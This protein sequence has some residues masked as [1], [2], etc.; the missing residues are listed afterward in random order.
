VGHTFLDGQPAPGLSKHQD[1]SRRRH[2]IFGGR[3]ESSVDDKGNQGDI[4]AC[5]LCAGHGEIHK[6]LAVVR[7]RSPQFREVIRDFE[8]DALMTKEDPLETR[9]TVNTASDHIVTHRSWKE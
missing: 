7:L 6:H 9:Q 8:E 2:R 5:P 1:E 4:V 3:K